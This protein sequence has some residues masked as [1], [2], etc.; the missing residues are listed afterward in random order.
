MVNQIREEDFEK[1]VVQSPLPVLVDFYATW[2]G[3][4]KAIAPIVEEVAGEWEGKVKVVKVD[5]DEAQE[6]AARYGIMGVPTLMIF[7]GGRDVAR[8]TGAVP[9]REI[10]RALEEAL[11][12]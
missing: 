10:V 4:C 11:G 2:C 9:K 6:T 1:E 12:G 7:R 8:V 3:P 5:V